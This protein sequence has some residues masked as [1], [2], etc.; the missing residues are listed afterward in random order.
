MPW[1]ENDHLF[2]GM[3]GLRGSVAEDAGLFKS[4][5][6]QIA[7]ILKK[8]GVADMPLGVDVMEPPMFCA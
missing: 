3:L 7:D 6:K 2:A 1:I 8:E 5:A 4:A